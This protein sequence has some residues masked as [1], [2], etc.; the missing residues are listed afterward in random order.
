LNAA[1]MPEMLVGGNG[2]EIPGFDPSDDPLGDPLDSGGV[3][4]VWR[5]E[6][7]EKRK[8]KNKLN[9]LFCKSLII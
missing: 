2:N 4:V 9:F 1:E 7:S 5:L 8:N 3:D 6:I